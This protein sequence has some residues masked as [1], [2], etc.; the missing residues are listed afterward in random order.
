MKKEREN[1][2]ETAK[3]TSRWQEGRMTGK[4][5]GYRNYGYRPQPDSVG[6]VDYCKEPLEM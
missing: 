2:Q 6:L 1:V 4:E 3:K 5:V